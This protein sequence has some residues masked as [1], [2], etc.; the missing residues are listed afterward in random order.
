METR[1]R[2]A[3]RVAGMR[4]GNSV[5]FLHIDAVWRVRGVSQPFCFQ[6]VAAHGFETLE[7]TTREASLEMRKIREGLGTLG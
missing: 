2:V 7:G 6:E 1:S 4:S 3:S 5:L